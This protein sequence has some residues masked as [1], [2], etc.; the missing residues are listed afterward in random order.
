M[1]GPIRALSRVG[2]AL[3]L[4]LS[5]LTTAGA[6]DVKEIAVGILTQG[7]AQGD[8]S[9]IETH[10]AERYI[11][12]N[13]SVPDG[14]KGLLAFVKGLQDLEGGV[15]INPIRVLQDGNLVAVHSEA[16][17]GS[18]RVVV[19]DLF[20]I[21]DGRA[22]EHWDAV[23]PRPKTTVSGRTMTDGPTE[24]TNRDQTEAN[25]A[26][27]LEFYQKVLIEGQVSLA[28]EYLGDYYHQHNPQIADGLEGFTAFFKHIQDNQI[29]FRLTTTH[30]SIAEGNFV[31]LHSEG[32]IDETPHAFFD[33]FRV[34]N[35]KIVEHWDVVQAVPEK[36]A[37]DNGMF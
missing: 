10:V 28:S 24:I 2:G 4:T 22:A 14:R 13:P 25:R 11:Q 36:M 16:R 5:L 18:D 33:L 7:I 29:P 12:H 20:R 26:L 6:S 17:F 35:G 15:E 1:K 37:H 21:E 3:A 30:R 9:F 34:E 8:R 31:L 23:Q 32:Q 27:V 19:F